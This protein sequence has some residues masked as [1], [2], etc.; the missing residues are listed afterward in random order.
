[1]ELAMTDTVTAEIYDPFKQGDQAYLGSM[2]VEIG[3][4]S[5][6]KRSKDPYD[7]DEL[8]KVVTSV[9]QRSYGTARNSQLISA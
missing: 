7:Q 8:A 2:D 6:T 3:F 4:A 9:S 5:K 1:M